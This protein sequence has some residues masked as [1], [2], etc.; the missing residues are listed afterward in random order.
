MFAI[1]HPSH[2]SYGPLS[3]ATGSMGGY[4]VAEAVVRVELSLRGGR[5]VL[6]CSVEVEPGDLD[7]VQGAS[8][9]SQ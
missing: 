6:P 8:G 5:S 3:T 1:P 9:G 7:P 4:R 2:D